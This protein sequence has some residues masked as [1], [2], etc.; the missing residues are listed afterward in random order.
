MFTQIRNKILNDSRCPQSQVSGDDDDFQRADDLITYYEGGHGHDHGD[1][2]GH[3]HDHGHGHSHG[4]EDDEAKYKKAMGQLKCVLAVGLFF[5]TAQGI[6]A[7]LAGSIAVATDC[8]HLASDLVGFCMSMVALAL[9]R[10]SASS[11]YTFGWHRSEIIGTIVSIVFLLTLTIWLLVEASKRFFVY[12]EIDGEIML[13]TAILSLFFNIAMMKVL[14]QGPGHDHD[15]DHGDGH[16]HG[17]DHGPP[18][19]IKK[20]GTEEAE[21]HGHDHGDMNE[22]KA[23]AA[24]EKQKNINVEAAYLHALSDMLLSIGVCIAAIIIYIWPVKQHPW[25]KYADPTCTVFFSIVVCLTCKPILANCVYILM[26]G[27]PEVVDTV[28]LVKEINALQ[29][30]KVKVH[31]FHVWSLSKGKYSLSCHI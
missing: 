28:A 3:G 4:D 26:E 19:K 9:T 5:V 14:H 25:S 17:H 8:A 10:K 20:K 31:D 22:S 15:H 11:E 2:H 23:A 18:K 16:S 24:A 13:I 12:Y 6:G 30:G 29:D 1:G 21:A 7:Y 27:A